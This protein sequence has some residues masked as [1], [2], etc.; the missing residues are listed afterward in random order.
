MGEYIGVSQMGE[1][2]NGVTHISV[3][4]ANADKLDGDEVL[5]EDR[6]GDRR[7]D[8]L[9]LDLEDVAHSEVGSAFEQKTRKPLLGV[10]V[11]E[12][13]SHRRLACWI[14]TVTEA[15]RVR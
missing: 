6:G 15:T 14:D 4:G 3:V 11:E 13:E 7:D 1:G 2:E 12:E 8:Q 9:S 10:G 5:V